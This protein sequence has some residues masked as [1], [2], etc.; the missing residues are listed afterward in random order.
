[1]SLGGSRSPGS[2]IRQVIGI[3]SV[4]NEPQRPFAG[5]REELVVELRFAEVASIRRIRYIVRIFEF[6]RIHDLKIKTEGVGNGPSLSS[7]KLGNAGR[8]SHH[9]DG[10]R[11]QLLRCD[12]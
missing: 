1:M 5:D 7:L 6:G 10:I 12:Q 9:A 3:S 8:D 4:R 11:S 2:M